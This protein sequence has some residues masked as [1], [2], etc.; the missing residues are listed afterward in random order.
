MSTI[1]KIHYT[2]KNRG[3]RKNDLLLK[4]CPNSSLIIPDRDFYEIG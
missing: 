2:I 3:L 4:L 1:F